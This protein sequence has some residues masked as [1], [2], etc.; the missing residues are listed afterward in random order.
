MN[1]HG[2]R[3]T[4]PL[5]FDLCTCPSEICLEMHA[6]AKMAEMALNCQNRQTVNKHSNKMAKG[7]FGKWRCWRKW[8]IWRKWQNWP[9]IA[10]IAD[11]RLQKLSFQVANLF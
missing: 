10:K 3:D 6:L 8:C 7:P 4:A 2:L 9:L 11:N 1:W 5:K